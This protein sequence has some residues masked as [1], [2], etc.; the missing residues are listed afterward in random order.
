DDLPDSALFIL[1]NEFF[2]ALPIRQFTRHP[3]GWCETM[4]GLDGDRVVLGRSAP[5]NLASLSG[6]LADTVPG[7]VVETCPAGIPVVTAIA[8]RI[9]TQGGAAMVIDYGGWRS[10]G[11]TFQALRAHAYADPL[12]SPGTADL[13]AHV[14]FEPLA[15]AATATGACVHGP[16]GQ[17]LLLDRLGIGP[18]AQALARHMIGATLDSHAKA[19]HRLTHPSEM[20]TLFQAMAI[21]PPDTPP[22]AGFAP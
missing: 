2:D 8:S 9:A 17:G 21:C 4:V 19:L 11:D 22:P 6:R 13:T 15:N 7:D 1:A 18:R 5:A 16:I 3:D 10:K 12:A 20:G 14:D